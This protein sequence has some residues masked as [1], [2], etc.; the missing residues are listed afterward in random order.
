[1]HHLEHDFPVPFTVS[2]RAWEC[3]DDL[4][5]NAPSTG[6][7]ALDRWL[8]DVASRP[9][10]CVTWT[11]AGALFRLHRQHWGVRA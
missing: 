10:E 1:M 2:R 9:P 5:R 7:A 11:E 4:T 6:S 8:R 3:A